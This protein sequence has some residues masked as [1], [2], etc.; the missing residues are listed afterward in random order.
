MDSKPSNANSNHSTGI[1]FILIQIRI[2]QKEFEAIEN[3]SKH[4]K[5][6]SNHS[7]GIRSIQMQIRTIQQ[8]FKS[9]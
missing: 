2:N 4:S 1:Q 7:K 3:Y 6:N 8:G 5:S 9:F